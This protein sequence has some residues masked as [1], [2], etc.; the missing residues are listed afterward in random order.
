MQEPSTSTHLHD[1]ALETSS[2]SRLS[3]VGGDPRLQP[4]M[5]PHTGVNEDF[6]TRLINFPSEIPEFGHSG[7]T[8]RSHELTA[9]NPRVNPQSTEQS[10]QL[11]AGSVFDSRWLQQ[12]HKV[13]SSE[14]QHHS[15]MPSISPKQHNEGL[16]ED[17]AKFPGPFREQSTASNLNASNNPASSSRACEQEAD[18]AST[19]GSTVSTQV[20]SIFDRTHT[21]CRYNIPRQHQQGQHMLPGHSSQTAI[22]DQVYA[23]ATQAQQH[24]F[25]QQFTHYQ[26][27]FPYNPPPMP[28]YSQRLYPGD[29]HLRWGVSPISSSQDPRAAPPYIT[30]EHGSPYAVPGYMQATQA[31]QSDL[32]PMD[33]QHSRPTLP[34]SSRR[35]ASMA[36]YERLKAKQ[37]ADQNKAMFISNTQMQHA[38]NGYAPPQY[39]P[40]SLSA[41][42]YRQFP[43]QN[44]GEQYALSSHQPGREFNY[45]PAPGSL[46]PS[47]FRG[48]PVENPSTRFTL[49]P[50]IYHQA[51]EAMN[52]RSNG[53]PSNVY[54]RLLRSGKPNMLEAL[55]KE[56]M[57]FTTSTA[58]RQGASYGVVRLGNVSQ[59]FVS[60][61]MT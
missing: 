18:A 46:N 49:S 17:A 41:S 24:P 14:G 16:D 38:L 26:T 28:Q 23:N 53:G 3:A 11:Q 25:H 19:T 42:P 15:P 7:F 55:S 22:Q 5:S 34:P 30:D 48:V 58:T 45:I 40:S 27:G 60:Q 56:N 51:S 29:Q 12:P 52:P 43:Q 57:P 10:S 59:S 31:L 6:S 9:E 35:Q 32:T 47:Q 39:M 54:Q 44:L 13:W 21:S 61:K 2:V 36:T 50:N 1:R 20:S 33:L 8:N 4:Q 37:L